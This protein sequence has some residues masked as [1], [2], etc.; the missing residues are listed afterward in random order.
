MEELNG[1]SYFPQYTKRVRYAMSIVE[2]NHIQIQTW[3]RKYHEGVWYRVEVMRKAFFKNKEDECAMELNLYRG[4]MR[5]AYKV[6]LLYKT[7]PV[8][9]TLIGFPVDEK[10]FF[11][12]TEEERLIS[13]LK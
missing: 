4:V 12:C 11:Q 10:D 9:I 3:V 1:F 6:L 2:T 5:E 7:N 13:T 8:N